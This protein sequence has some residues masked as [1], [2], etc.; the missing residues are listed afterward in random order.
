MLAHEDQPIVRAE[1]DDRDGAAVFHD[2]ALAALPVGE[3]Q[4]VDVE[5]DDATLVDG[6]PGDAPGVQRLAHWPVL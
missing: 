6:P 1:G 2:L 5:A 4:S 3:L